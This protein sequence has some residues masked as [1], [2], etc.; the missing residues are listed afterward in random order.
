MIVCAMYFCDLVRQYGIKFCAGEAY[1]PGYAR[2]STSSGRRKRRRGPEKR[3]K[4]LRVRRSRIYNSR[5]FAGEIFFH[6]PHER[7]STAHADGAIL[8]GM[9]ADV[10]LMEELL[11]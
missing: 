7:P 11:V 6:L 5:R 8:A 4:V 10:T 9:N 3:Q 2:P 1:G